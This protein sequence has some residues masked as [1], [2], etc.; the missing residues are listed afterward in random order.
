VTARVI[1]GRVCERCGKPYKPHYV[2][3]ADG[4]RHY[5]GSGSRFCSMACWR[6]WS[7]VEPK[8]PII[9]RTLT[10][11]EILAEMT[12]AYDELTEYIAKQDAEAKL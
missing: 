10:H 5:V 8:V 9:E 1:H 7:A 11:A 4:Q 6:L 3:G 2:L 12:E